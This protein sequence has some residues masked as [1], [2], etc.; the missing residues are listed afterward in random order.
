MSWQ[1]VALNLILRL[2]EKP[3]LAR[4]RD[5]E[6]IRARFERRARWLFRPPRDVLERPVQ[7]DTGSRGLE[8]LRVGD[9]ADT[10]PVI[11][12]FHGGAYVFGSP[13]THAALAARLAQLTGLPVCLP[14]YR[15]APEYPFP[16]AVED[17]RAA[18]DALAASGIPAGRIVLGGDSAGGGLALALLGDLC[19]RG[20]DLPAAA[21]AFSPLTDLGFS[22]DS[23]RANAARD[24]MLPAGRDRDMAQMYLQ[25][26]DPA[27]PLASPLMADFTGAGPVWLAAGDT[28]IMLDDTRRMA[29]HL[30]RQGVTVEEVIARDLPHVWPFFWRYLPEGAATLRALAGW[31]SRQLWRSGES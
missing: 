2:T 29:A 19:A 6:V 31:I 28:E 10:G 3:H 8:G 21:F 7:L 25:G 26:A 17:A 16:A 20:A 22:G 15:K 23:F 30:R 18:F 4:V 13:R 14:D 1:R 5:P 11:L 27:Q 24:V 12:Y 9:G